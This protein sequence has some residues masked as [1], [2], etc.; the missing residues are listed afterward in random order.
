[1]A[2]TRFYG[3]SETELRDHVAAVGAACTRHTNRVIELANENSH[4]SQ[5][6][7][8]R[9]EA[10]L[11][12]LRALIPAETLVSMG[13]NC[14]GQA[15]EIEAPGGSAA[16]AYPLALRGADYL[17]VHVDRSREIWYRTRQA[18]ELETMSL[19]LN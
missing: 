12:S 10:T 17:T 3:F 11:R 6:E 7:A 5:V 1:M 16:E 13:S 4:P 18:R 19:Q 8:L 15:D 2:A 9:D 14:C